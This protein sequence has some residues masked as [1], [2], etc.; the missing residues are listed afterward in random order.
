MTEQTTAIGFSDDSGKASTAAG[1]GDIIVAAPIDWRS[2]AKLTLSAYNDIVIDSGIT[3][4]GAGSLV[5]TTGNNIGGASASDTGVIF[6][7]GSIQFTGQ[8]QGAL[9]IN[10]SAYGLIWSLGQFSA[11][12]A[13][14]H[15]ALAENI[16]ASGQ[17]FT[18]SPYSGIFSGIFNGLGNGIS[19]L[20]IAGSASI[21]A[22]V[23]LFAN[24]GAT[25]VVRNIALSGVNIT[26]NYRLSRVGAPAG[27]NSGTIADS[28]AS[29][30]VA[31]GAVEIG[32]LVGRNNGRIENSFASGTVTG[33]GNL[34]RL[35]GLAGANYGTILDSAASAAVLGTGNA[36][37]GGFP[38]IGGLAGFD[39]GLIENS[40]AT[41]AVTGNGA[42][43]YAGGLVGDLT[44]I[45]TTGTIKTSY[46]TGAVTA[47][48]ANSHAGGLV[49]EN[50]GI[51]ADSYWDTQT[52]GQ[53]NAVAGATGLTTDALASA[54]P[55]GFSSS[56]WGDVNGQSTPYLL[57]L[58]AVNQAVYFAS[59]ST[60]LKDNPTLTN[61][62]LVY[63]VQSAAGLQA[64]NSN[65]AGAYALL[66]DINAAGFGFSPIGETSAFTGVFD[67]LGNSI[68]NLTI[69][70]PAGKYVGLFG[71][72]GA[73]GVVRNVTLANV[74]ITGN[75]ANKAIGALAGM[76]NGTVINSS[77]S[78]TV[79]GAGATGSIGGLLGANAGQVSGSD[80]SVTV[81]GAS[82]GIGVSSVGGLVGLNVIGGTIVDSAASG[83]VGGGKNAY[84]G[85]LAGV[86]R[87]TL[88][89]DYAT[90]AVTSTATFVKVGGLVGWALGGAI[91]NSFA[92]GAVTDTGADSSVG[93]LAGELYGGL[94]N[95][96][97]VGTVA[98]SF[99]TGAVTAGTA[100]RAGGF[101]GNIHLGK[102]ADSFSTGTVAAGAGSYGGGFAG[103]N[104]DGTI[105]DSYWDITTSGHSNGVGGGDSSGVTGLTTNA[106][107]AALPAGFSASV[108]GDLGGQ[109]T[110]YLLAD[111]SVDQPV[112][113]SAALALG[114]ANASPSASLAYVV[115]DVQ[116]LQAINDN[117]AADYV[118]AG[119]IDA[120]NFAFSPIGESSAFTGIFDGLG[121]TISNLTIDESS[122]R[123]VGLFG[124]VGASGVV[125]N[126]D[127]ADA[128]VTASNDDD[129]YIGALAGRNSGTVANDRVTGQVTGSITHY[130]G[131]QA[132]GGLV[133]FN[134]PGGTIEGSQAGDL[135]DGS[136]VKVSV[137]G[138]AGS[139]WGSIEAS[140]ATGEVT[141]S[142]IGSSATA[143]IGGLAG[144][145]LGSISL[146]YAAGKVAGDGTGAKVGGLIGYN[147]GTIDDGYA[148]GAVSGDAFSS[149][150][151]FAGFNQGGATISKS[152]STGAVTGGKYAGGFAG[153]NNG[154]FKD[155]YWDITTSGQSQGVGVGSSSGVTGL[156]T[157]VLAGALPTGFSASVWG[158]LGGESTPY[159]L[160]DASADQP[161]YLS[162]ALALSMANASPS[163]SLAY[164]VQDVQGLQAIND[165]LAADYVL[166]GDIDAANFNFSPIGL[167]VSGFTG[168]LDGLGHSISNLTINKSFQDVG[169]FGV[170]SAG[171]LVE[172]LGLDDAEITGNL[173]SADIGALAGLNRGTI[174]NSYANGT[175]T[176]T[177]EFDDVGGLV[178]V[179]GGTIADSY[180][181]AAA[182]ATQAFSDVGGLVGKNAGKIT[183]CLTLGPVSGTGAI[184]AAG[185]FAGRN[186]GTITDS[187]WDIT[188]SGQSKGVGVGSSS[189]LRALPTTTLAKSLPTGFSASVWGDLGGQT[190]PYLLADA[191]ADQPVYFA[192]GSAF[193]K[194]NPTLTDAS[195]VYV[196]QDVQGLQAINNNLSGDYALATNISAAN[197][198]FSPIGE[199]SPFTGVFDGLGQTI[200]GLTINDASG[201]Y[202]DAGLFGQIGAGGTVENLA[203][204][205]VNITGAASS[206]GNTGALAGSNDGTVLNSY[207]SGTVTATGNSARIGGLVGENYGKV[208]DSAAT[209][210]VTD[211]GR[212]LIM[213]G[214]AGYNLGLIQDSY[215]NG[216]VNKV[217]GGTFDSYVWVGGLAGANEGRIIDSYA[218]G[219]ITIDGHSRH[220]FGFGG[221]VGY[222]RSGTIT[223]SYWDTTTSGQSQGV[224]KGSDTG[225]TGLTTA[226]LTAALPPGFSPSVWGDD[227]GQS[228]PYLLALYFVN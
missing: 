144:S 21:I 168:I 147:F 4:A 150:G 207:A 125:E 165:N 127:I 224:G 51:I 158:D 86:N 182:T 203:L 205:N 47:I 95:G 1:P 191:A 90:G 206:L 75:A 155:N 213:G 59:N 189:G 16:N 221:L 124:Q 24:I 78:G 212:A 140:D 157:D 26:G 79:N 6:G 219:K 216:A 178:G 68:S 227:N 81:S 107:A 166:A 66:A 102:I 17:N 197:F 149:V 123:Y 103:Y 196:V 41:G 53:N 87:G 126:T 218:T 153:G 111:A 98:N 28:F 160:A 9:S 45:A 129:L 151:G 63:A 46:A 34:A 99:A 146:V 176:G 69:N 42:G 171:G 187:F 104:D 54:L 228:L 186:T 118:L 20:T 8:G 128:N 49:A 162:G 13:G 161:V 88:A 202:K 64:I 215:A 35:G 211:S 40:Y 208:V 214:L 3:A 85:G 167:G 139:N 32:G 36:T 119:D 222:N 110:P 225:A 100:S 190:T 137:G 198:A 44:A 204:A 181:L 226:Q 12:N 164:V 15:Y 194:A 92:T 5:L 83:A 121:H 120:A 30:K 93:G 210:A 50:G 2:A 109:S 185:G 101:V 159:L 163:A 188:T 11:M 58:K 112:Y 183:Q 134:A 74:S 141:G 67:G 175:V 142:G 201:D 65:L 7:G 108:W 180:V 106:L 192:T 37:S 174:E 76:N 23:G 91:E 39:T 133:G 43:A 72:I 152:Y 195:Q 62:D 22:N 57:A 84:I 89:D 80:A 29:G 14:G 131:V 94:L 38:A 135:V 115:Q 33:S 10:G 200:S 18:L 117:L 172:N 169:L 136:G 113:L 105:T 82:A 132:I 179:N 96:V 199:T 220:L 73:G 31:G 55:G 223:D 209:V 193:L 148:T 177:A 145:N 114:M 61:A 143:W 184:T 154:T 71:Q 60:F 27:D 138:L 217:T 19:N 56:V 122:D 97:Y 25:G 173:G 116:G 130:G 77:A 156:T 70:D 52:T 48:G 170:I